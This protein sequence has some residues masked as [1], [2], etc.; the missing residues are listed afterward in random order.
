MVFKLL[1]ERAIND[2][3][4]N[5][6]KMSALIFDEFYKKTIQEITSSQNTL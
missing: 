3:D 6:K 5:V 1:K 2:G 4:E